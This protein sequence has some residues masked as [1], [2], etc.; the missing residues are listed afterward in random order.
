MLM[1]ATSCGANESKQ[2]SAKIR[3]RQQLRKGGLLARGRRGCGTPR[4]EG[5]YW[6]SS[7]CSSAKPTSKVRVK[8]VQTPSP[9]APPYCLAPSSS[10][11]LFQ[12]ETRHLLVNSHRHF[13]SSKDKCKVVLHTHTSRMVLP[14][15]KYAHRW[16]R[17]FRSRYNNR[18]QELRAAWREFS[19]L[20]QLE[21]AFKKPWRSEF[22][23]PEGRASMDYEEYDRV[24]QGSVIGLYKYASQGDESV[25][26]GDHSDSDA[27]SCS[28]ESI[29]ELAEPQNIEDPP[30][31]A[32]SSPCPSAA[33]APN[34]SPLNLCHRCEGINAE[35]LSGELGYEHGLLSELPS[36]DELDQLKDSPASGSSRF[37]K[38]CMVFMEALRD[39][40]IG[41]FVRDRLRLVLDLEGVEKEQMQEQDHF[42]SSHVLSDRKTVTKEKSISVLVL[43][44]M[45]LDLIERLQT[46]KGP[47]GSYPEGTF[48]CT[49]KLGC[50]TDEN[51]P[52]VLFGI[53]PV[54]TVGASTSSAASFEVAAAW[55][56][57][58]LAADPPDT[59]SLSLQQVK[60][61]SWDENGH[62]LGLENVSGCPEV[63]HSPGP[64]RPTRLLEIGSGSEDGIVRLIEKTEDKVPYA[65][66]S[67][68]W[69]IGASTVQSE[70]L[71][72]ATNV[73]SRRAG[74]QRSDLPQTLQDGITVSEKLG[75]RH[76]WID[77]LCIIQDSKDDWTTEAAKMS[78][79]YLGSLV[80]IVAAAS[81]SVEHGCFNQRS[82]ST[83]EALRAHEFLVSIQS[84]FSDGRKSN[85]HIITDHWAHHDRYP[86]G[87]CLK[88]EDLYEGQVKTG[89]W[90]D[91]AWTLQE[92]VLSKRI[93]FYTSEMLLWECDHCRLSEDRFPQTQGDRLYPLELVD[94]GAWRGPDPA[95]TTETWYRGLVEQYSSRQ[96]TFEG[97]KMVAIGALAKVTSWG[98]HIPYLAGLWGDS[99]R[100][101]I[102]WRRDGPGSKS[103]TMTCPSWS[104]ASQSSPVSYRLSNFEI[105]F[106]PPH[107]RDGFKPQV[108]DARVEAADVKNPFGNVK[109]GYVMLH[110]K[111][112]TARVLRDF[113]GRV[114]PGWNW[115]TSDARGLFIDSG[116]FMSQWPVAAFMDDEYVPH[117]VLV[118][119]VGRLGNFV[120]L[121]LT[122]PKLDA[123]EYRRVGITVLDYFD[124]DWGSF[125]DGIV[126]SQIKQ[127]T[128][129]TIKIV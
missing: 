84:S 36:H 80:T 8:S 56:S 113:L 9:S 33:D 46:Y 60:S 39:D 92:H 2:E 20:D 118:A 73:D 129:R 106:D 114:P 68:C 1:C 109:S 120:A 103:K 5:G 121:L 74:F 97:D 52:S 88:L 100:S 64:E 66:L 102:M 98:R 70:W 34:D 127:W 105:V 126:G 65:T 44:I 18:T 40:N 110:T 32:S 76:L 28:E 123:E 104:W 79:I 71:T 37:C 11:T 90:F 35:S 72:T 75:L 25:F 67:Y 117:E 87:E 59:T 21:E 128:T 55:L 91:R 48:I 45:N 16:G 112:R 61:S 63:S 82:I 23:K 81:S 22:S 50:F 125:R 78:G 94:S 62:L 108:V 29:P 116:T 119:L 31:Q 42:S 51:D 10:Q 122:P 89:P 124:W 49:V 111:L 26:R 54:R 41:M 30:I 13:K 43:R 95:L 7:P 3:C 17:K 93:L 15:K 69:G 96:L 19:S 101:G 12:P 99:V 83:M 58:C 4:G 115:N 77:A 107:V 27:A 53:T 47:R 85:L 24:W 14:V 38:L 57:Q 6:L 86:Y